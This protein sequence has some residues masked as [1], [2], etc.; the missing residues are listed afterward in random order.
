[1][2]H[3]DATIAVAN[4]V[5]PAFDV[6]VATQ[7]WHPP[8]HHSFAAPLL[9]GPAIPLEPHDAEVLGAWFQDDTRVITVPT[10]YGANGRATPSRRWPPGGRYDSPGA[11]RPRR[12]VLV[13]RASGRTGGAHRYP[14]GT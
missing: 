4:A 7:D 9:D 14:E 1:M 11:S 5:M 8:D 2:P 6:V 13:C 12:G 3:G 10:P